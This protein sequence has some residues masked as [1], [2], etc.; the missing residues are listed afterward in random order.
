MREI[1]LDLL[2]QRLILLDVDVDGVH[3][4]IIRA[5]G[6]IRDILARI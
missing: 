3:V 6:V 4:R 2:K 1:L 5:A